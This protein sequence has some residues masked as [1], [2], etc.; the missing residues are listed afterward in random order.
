MFVR[1]K[2]NKKKVKHFMNYTLE[3]ER[4]LFDLKEKLHLPHNIQRSSGQ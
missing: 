4:D 1:K 2:K 3:M